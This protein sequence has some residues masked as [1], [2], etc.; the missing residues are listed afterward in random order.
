MS[1]PPIATN[2]W[3]NTHEDLKK[4]HLQL[5]TKASFASLTPS[6]S[7]SETVDPFNKPSITVPFRS[8]VADPLVTVTVPG[9]EDLPTKLYICL[10][11][12]N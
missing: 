5:Q 2:G 4:Y 6:K 7:R 10:N 11:Y 3:Y 9:S 8:L 12:L 1:V